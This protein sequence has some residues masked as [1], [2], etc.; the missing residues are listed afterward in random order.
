MI[1]LFKALLL[2]QERGYLLRNKEGLR[3]KAKLKLVAI[4]QHR[5]MI[6]MH[7]LLPIVMLMEISL[8]LLAKTKSIPHCVLLQ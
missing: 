2:R 6:P 8:T 4:F 7:G 5:A 3:E 1:A